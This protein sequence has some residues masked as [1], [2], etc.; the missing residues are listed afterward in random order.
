MAVEAERQC[1][2]AL[3][4]AGASS[5]A[6][7]PFAAPA[8]AVAAELGSDVVAGLSSS[9][10]A[11]R[12]R[13]YGPNRPSRVERAPYL[14]IAARQVADPLVALLVAAIAVSAAIGEQLNAAIIGAIVVLNV[15]LG[16]T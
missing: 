4:P 3:D 2:L 16:F 14:S 13:L 9:T 10:A 5:R 12:R 8:E 7:A 6:A 1:A 11:E 15:L